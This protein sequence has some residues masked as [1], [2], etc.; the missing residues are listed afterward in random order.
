MTHAA[1]ASIMSVTCGPRPSTGARMP[2]S[3]IA[4]AVAK[5]FQM[6]SAYLITTATSKPPMP[7]TMTTPHVLHSKPRVGSRSTSSAPSSVAELCSTASSTLLGTVHAHSCIFLC[8][9]DAVAAVAS[10]PPPSLAAPPAPLSSRSKYTDANEDEKAASSTATSPSAMLRSWA[11]PT[12]EAAGFFSSWS[13]SCTRTMPAMRMSCESHCQR[14]RLRPSI[15]TESSAVRIVFTWYVIWKTSGS[16]LESATYRM[17]F[18][19]VKQS[20]GTARRD[21]STGSR[22][23]AAARTGARSVHACTM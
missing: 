21:I 8:H 13:L 22:T 23:S 3:T 9:S 14:E 15:F 7:L 2:V 5:P 16:R 10:L 4:P 6:L 18:W 17:L 11:P 20:A 12:A 19:S 1:P